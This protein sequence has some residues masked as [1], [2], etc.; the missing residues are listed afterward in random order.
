MWPKLFLI[1][2]QNIK[3]SLR[4]FLTIN[5]MPTVAPRTGKIIKNGLHVFERGE[6]LPQNG[7]ITFLQLS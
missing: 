6:N 5:M 1:T 2:P 3:L 7:G 4:N